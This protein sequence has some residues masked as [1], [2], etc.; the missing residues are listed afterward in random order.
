[1]PELGVE[2]QQRLKAAAV[3]VVGAGGLGCPTTM[4]LAAAGVGKIGIVDG[5]TI[6]RSNLHRQVLHKESLVGTSKAVSIALFVS[7][8]NSNVQCVPYTTRLTPD[9]A[10]D[11]VQ[12][13]DM[14]VD[15]TDNVATRYLLNDTAVLSKIPLVSGSALRA[16]Y[17]PPPPPPPPPFLLLATLLPLLPAP[18]PPR[19]SSAHN[20]KPIYHCRPL[21]FV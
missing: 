2:G 12:G 10:L 4:Y 14:L 17:P 18:P 20:A 13:Y 7:G 8:L 21:F 19:N 9:N 15:C 6:E 11:I 3:L 1:M 16:C 5:D